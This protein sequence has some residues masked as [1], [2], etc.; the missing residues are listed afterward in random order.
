MEKKKKKVEIKKKFTK[1]NKLLNEDDFSIA[2]EKEMVKFYLPLSMLASKYRS[3]KRISPSLKTLKP[4]LDQLLDFAELIEIAPKINE[5]FTPLIHE[6]KNNKRKG[7][8]LKV[9]RIGYKTIKGKVLL[10]A[11]VELK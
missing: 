10:K 8:I 2:V 7:K 5:E 4:L 11:V 1:L 6:V 3:F 9:F